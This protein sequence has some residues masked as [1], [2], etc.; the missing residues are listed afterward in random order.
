MINNKI[1]YYQSQ[2]KGKKHKI[3]IMIRM[4]YKNN[5]I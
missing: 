2:I 1:D 5:K 3:T 4:F